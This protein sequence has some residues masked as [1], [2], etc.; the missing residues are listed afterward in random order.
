[1][2]V[3]YRELTG[4][5]MLDFVLEGALLARPGFE[6]DEDVRPDRIAQVFRE[7]VRVAFADEPALRLTDATL[8]IGIGTER[9][10]GLLHVAKLVSDAL[11]D[12]RVLRD[13]RVGGVRAI[14]VYRVSWTPHRH[15][16][17]V[18]D[19]TGRAYRREFDAVAAEWRTPT[20][21][22][23]GALRGGRWETAT[24]YIDW[25]HHVWQTASD[26]GAFRFVPGEMAVLEELGH[27]HAGVRRFSLQI[28]VQ[29]ERRNVD[30][31][32]VAL[33]VLDMLTLAMRDHDVHTPLDRLVGHIHVNHVE[34]HPDAVRAK[35]RWEPFRRVPG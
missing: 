31:D 26:D 29:T 12:V 6:D 21:I 4:N 16:V 8:A 13:D 34:E 33:Y 30:L 2:K 28:D 22:I 3:G 1:M 9:D 19:S 14:D 15:W 35:L 25:L 17:R 23:Q 20:P 5:L 11:V 27:Q 10:L 24:D 7:R 18:A 32:N